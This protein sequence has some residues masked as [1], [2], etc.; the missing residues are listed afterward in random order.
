MQTKITAN[1]SIRTNQKITIVVPFNT[2]S[3]E[4]HRD[5]ARHEQNFEFGGAEAS[6]FTPLSSF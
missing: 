6:R 5:V 4:E 3:S 2:D 1:G